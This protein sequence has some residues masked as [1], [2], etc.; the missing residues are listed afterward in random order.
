MPVRIAV[1]RAEIRTEYLRIKVIATPTCSILTE[2]DS[3][4]SD[5][6]LNPEPPEYEVGVESEEYF[7]RCVELYLHSPNKSSM[8]S[9]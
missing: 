3:W 1:N 6:D 7:A 8:C 9:T 2:E 5:L 4:S